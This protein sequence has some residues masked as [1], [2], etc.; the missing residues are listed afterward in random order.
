MASGLKIVFNPLSGQFEYVRRPGSGRRIGDPVV[1]VVNGANVTFTT[2]VNFVHEVPG[3]SI[4][5]YFNG[6]RLLEGAG[7][8]YTVSESGG[9]GTGYDTLTLA[10]PPI[11]SDNILVDYTES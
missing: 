1:G 11:T 3:D 9:L 10:V 7:N 5:V 2:V 8:D 6:V 4:A